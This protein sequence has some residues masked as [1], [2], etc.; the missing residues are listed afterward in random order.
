MMEPMDIKR[1]PVHNILDDTFLEFLFGLVKAGRILFLWLS[2]PCT[3]FSA[4]QNG[5]ASGPWRS[6]AHPEGI[7]KRAEITEGNEIWDRTIRLANY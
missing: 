1:D 4:L 5:H 2:P 6:K 7:Q 3:S